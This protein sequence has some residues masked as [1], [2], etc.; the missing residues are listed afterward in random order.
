MAVAVRSGR[1]CVKCILVLRILVD[2]NVTFNTGS[3]SAPLEVVVDVVEVVL[4]AD[5]CTRGSSSRCPP[6][7]VLSRSRC[8]GSGMPRA[9]RV[10]KLLHVLTC[11]SPHVTYMCV[12][13]F[14]IS[15]L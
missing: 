12:G 9:R 8:S 5:V 6:G 7:P 11:Y 3:G 2:L 4:V 15:D 1:V 10:W 14:L 13:S